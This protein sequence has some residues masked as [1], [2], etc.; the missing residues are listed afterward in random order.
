MKYNYLIFIILTYNLNLFCQVEQSIFYP[1]IPHTNYFYKGPVLEVKEY[2]YSSRKNARKI[3]FKS[4]LDSYKVKRTLWF[5]DGNK[6]EAME[7]EPL[8][9]S[10]SYVFDERIFHREAAKIMTKALM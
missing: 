4:S 5:N 3:L 7:D 8:P 1:I 9:E 10:E 6:L 2:Q